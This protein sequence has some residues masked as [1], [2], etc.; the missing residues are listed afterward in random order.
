MVLHAD[1]VGLSNE[2]MDV[3]KMN[4]KWLIDKK[5]AC[6]SLHECNLQKNNSFKS[7]KVLF[8]M[9]IKIIKTSKY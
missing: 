6:I 3:L 4:Y 5:C 2:G 1:Y 8:I 7:S 9:E